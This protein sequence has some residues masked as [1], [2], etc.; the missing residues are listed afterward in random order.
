M[1]CSHILCL[2]KITS[3]N[4][5]LEIWVVYHEGC[6]VQEY[7]HHVGLILN[8]YEQN[9]S[10]FATVVG[11]HLLQNIFITELS[12]EWMVTTLAQD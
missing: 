7:G 8:P 2:N 3:L 4:S 10:S 9:P 11:W 1:F 6:A 5:R 12:L